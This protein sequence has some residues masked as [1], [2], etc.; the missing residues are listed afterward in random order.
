MKRLE[1]LFYIENL[2]EM[3]LEYNRI[4]AMFMCDTVF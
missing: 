1:I 3:Y 4:Y 2:T